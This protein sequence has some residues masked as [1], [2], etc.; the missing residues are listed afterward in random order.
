VPAIL[1][2]PIRLPAYLDTTGIV[3]R[4][5]DSAV[6]VA[7]LHLWAGTLADAF[8]RVLAD[9][10]STLLETH[11]VSVYPRLPHHTADYQVVGEVMQ[12]DGSLAGQVALVVRWSVV[13][14]GERKPVASRQ[15]RISVPVG[16]PGYAGLVAAQSQAVA[17]L[18]RDIAAAI[19]E[20]PR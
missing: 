8:P 13:S 20:Q 12:L 9:N 2:G 5:S 19:R 10:L 4:N 11:L 7:Q 6:E 15:S 3:T 14:V 18:S 17:Q 16:E 1:V